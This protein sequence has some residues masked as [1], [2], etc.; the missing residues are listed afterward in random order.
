MKPGTARGLLV[1]L[2][3]TGCSHTSPYLSTGSKD[4]A[5]NRVPSL[6]PDY[7]LL[8]IGD[9]GVPQTE[10]PLLAL[11]SD[12]ASQFPQRTTVVFLGDNMYPE[13]ITPEH[14]HEADAI[15]GP[16]VQV[17]TGSGAEG[18]FIAG[19]HD[20]AYR[21][22]GDAGLQAVLRQAQ[23]ID[24]RLGDGSFLPAGG[25]PG[26]VVR[27]LPRENPSVRLVVLDTQWW[28]HSASK[29]AARESTVLEQLEQAVATELPVVI[30][31][32]HPLLSVGVHGG[33]FSWQDHL[34]PLTRLHQ[35]LWLPLP[36]FGTVYTLLRA[37]VWHSAQDLH[38]QENR[39][40]VDSLTS[41]LGTGQVLAYAAGHEHNLQVL[42]AEPAAQ[43]MLISGAGARRNLTPVWHRAETL[44]AHEH[45]GFMVL[46]FWRASGQAWLSVVEPGQAS[47]NPP[48]AEKGRVVFVRRLR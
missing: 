20:W 30:L 14:A 25:M 10:E 34:F 28:L 43:F 38:G 35:G 40:M 7:R 6:A 27:D 29:P 9:A 11:L 19:N 47:E 48:S 2:C 4:L 23:Y 13:G 1:L 44:F 32:H 46:D 3:F 37:H 31:A 12:W 5:S 36:I 17:V 33:H 18:V 42:A 16:Q 15:L 21:R 22:D 26:P 45:T 8:L 39:R 41:A 24:E